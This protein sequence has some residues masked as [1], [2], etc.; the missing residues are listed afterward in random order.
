MVRQFEQPRNRDVAVLVDLWQPERPGPR[1]PENVERAVSF[2]ATLVAELCRKGGSD[3]YLVMADPVLRLS[4]G[5]ASAAL[6]QEMMER[7]ALVEA[8]SRRANAQFASGCDPAD[9]TRHRGRAGQQPAGRLGQ[10]GRLGA[11]GRGRAQATCLA[12]VIDASSDE[13]GNIFRRSKL[14]D[15]TFDLSGT[16]G[17]EEAALRQHG[18]LGGLRHALVGH[19][20]TQPRTA[21]VCGWR[22]S[23]PWS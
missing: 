13:L 20:T 19:G 18:D 14:S 4:G 12:C 1:Q 6:L 9:R 11:V 16:N 22:P 15:S 5:P 7:L 17:P 8:R 21:L 3:V 23:S 10:S 2:A